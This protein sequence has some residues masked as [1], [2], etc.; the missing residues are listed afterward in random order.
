[1]LTGAQT[2]EN[3]VAGCLLDKVGA[4]KNEQ[5][6]SQFPNDLKVSSHA[7]SVE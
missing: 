1:M 3:K 4:I 6:F 7:L 5:G 2:D